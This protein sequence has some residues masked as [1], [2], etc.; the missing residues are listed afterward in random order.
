MADLGDLIANNIRGERARRRWTQAQLAER[1][2]WPRTSI[3]DIEIGRNPDRDLDA[4]P[5]CGG[6]GQLAAANDEA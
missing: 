4:P 5:F 3:H 1:L 2:G 6:R